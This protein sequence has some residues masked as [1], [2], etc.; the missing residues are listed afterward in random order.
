LRVTGE[1]A[2]ERLT[3]KDSGHKPYRRPGP[4]TVERAVRRIEAVQPAAVHDQGVVLLLHYDPEA[5]DAG[6]RGQA[7]VAREET[8]DFAISVR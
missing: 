3:G 4:D 2:R 6:E 8:G 5:T 1:D 7:V